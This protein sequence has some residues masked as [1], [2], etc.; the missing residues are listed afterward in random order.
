MFTIV[1]FNCVVFLSI[2]MVVPPPANNLNSTYLNQSIDNF[3]KMYGFGIYELAS[4]S[5]KFLNR[6]PDYQYRQE[7]FTFQ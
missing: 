6:N 4:S 1:K 5:Y 2:N 3:Q 7:Y